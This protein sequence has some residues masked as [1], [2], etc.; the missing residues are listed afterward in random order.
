MYF[1]VL[2]N[3]PQTPLATTLKPAEIDPHVP[4]VP[5]GMFKLNEIACLC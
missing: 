1:Q 4:E 2:V 3:G 5:L